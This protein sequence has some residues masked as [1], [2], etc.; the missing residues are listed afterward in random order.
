MSKFQT[1]VTTLSTGPR[2]HFFG[3]YGIN[4]WNRSMQF[5]L[6]LETDFHEHRPSAD[7]IASVGLIDCETNIFTK[8]AETSAFNL[9]QGSMMHWIDVGFGEEFTFN[10]WD[11]R[12][13]VSRAI[14]PETKAVRTIQGAIATVSPT[15][16]LAIGLNFGRMAHCRAVVG[17][18]NDVGELDFVPAPDDDGLF[19]RDRQ[20]GESRLIVSIAEVCR[21]SN[22]K[23]CADKRTWFNHVLFNTDGTRL[24]FFC[25]YKDDARMHTSLWTVN[26]DGTHL[27]CQ[28]P[29]GNRISHFAWRDPHR[30][31]ISTDYLGEMRFLE[32]TDRQRDFA[33][34]GAGRLPRDGHAC[35]FPDGNWLVCDAYPQKPKRLAEL[36]LFN[37][38]DHRKVN[39][40]KYYS[41]ER[42]TGDIRCDLHPRWS[43]DG[44]FITFD[45]VHEGTRQVYLVDVSEFV[46]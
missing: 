40:G 30:I 38:N 29:F 41:E 18:A 33:A 28:I 32:F 11:N 10:D 25:R 26:P 12:Q 45:S 39:L 22:D 4:P 9:Q 19:L 3:Y 21:K 1:T 13:L 35:Y 14:H 36:M 17:Y 43:P 24:L 42:F 8:Y 31:L 5:H 46:H 23:R 37:V 6:A 7:D 44:R 2:H 15:A 20:S 34:F 27:E 16:P